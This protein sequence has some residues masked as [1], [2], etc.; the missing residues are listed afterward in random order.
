MTKLFKKLLCLSLVFILIG[1][2]SKTNKDYPF[3]TMELFYLEDCSSCNAFKNNALPKIR[4]A[5][6]NNFEIKYYNL[7]FEENEQKYDEIIDQ[8]ENFDDEYYLSTPFIV[9]NR[10]FAIVG[11]SANEETELIK[12]IKRALNNEK[13]GDYYKIGR[14]TFKGEKS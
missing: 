1:C 13:L 3:F 4:K 12:E 8:L 11:Y 7:D 10:D 9:I 6:N 14:F 5:F 2:S